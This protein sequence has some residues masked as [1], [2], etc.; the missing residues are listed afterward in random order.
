MLLQGWPKDRLHELYSFSSSEMTLLGGHAFSGFSI[1]GML[2]ATLYG[3]YTVGIT[4]DPDQLV[5]PAPPGHDEEPEV[6][7]ISDSN[8]GTTSDSD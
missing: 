1:L 4:G 6:A 7:S 5:G 2:T 3:A 8:S